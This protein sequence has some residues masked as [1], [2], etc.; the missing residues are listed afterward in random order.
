[1]LPNF[2]LKLKTLATLRVVHH[3]PQTEY[4]SEHEGRLGYFYFEYPR[5][6][7]TETEETRL[8]CVLDFLYLRYPVR[9]LGLRLMLTLN[10]DFFETPIFRYLKLGVCP[11][12]FSHW[13]KLS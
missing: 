5:L 3:Y 2:D 10:Y 11:V 4:F 7:L 8:G 6:S 13:D 1:M 9:I 12:L